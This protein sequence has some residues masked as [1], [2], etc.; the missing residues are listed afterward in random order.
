EQNMSGFFEG[1]D[2]SWHIARDNP[3]EKYNAF[4][5]AWQEQGDYAEERWWDLGTYSSSLIIPE[6]YAADFGLN[7]S[8]HTFVTFESSP[9]IPHEG[10]PATLM[11]VHNLH[12]INFLWQGLYFNH[13][14]Y[15]KIQTIG[16]NGSEGHEDRLRVHLLH[17]VDSLRQS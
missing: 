1:L 13:E 3:F 4:T 17:C 7:R 2:R 11:M 16:W 6:K 14:Y 9:G 10:Y 5:A 15:R 12:C 8:K